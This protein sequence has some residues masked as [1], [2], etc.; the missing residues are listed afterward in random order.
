LGRQAA[1]APHRA[2]TLPA[3]VASPEYRA[4]NRK[5]PRAGTGKRADR[6]RGSSGV[7][8]I[9]LPFA[10]NSTVPTARAL[11]RPRDRTRATRTTSVAWGFGV[12]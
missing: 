12:W 4:R 8:P 2:D 3:W 10:R 7:R 9:S 6:D 5:L 1:R 11:W